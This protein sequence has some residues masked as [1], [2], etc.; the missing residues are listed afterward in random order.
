MTPEQMDMLVAAHL[1]AENTGDVAA[2]VAVYT[3]DV[4]HDVVGAPAGP[5]RGPEAARHRYEQLLKEVR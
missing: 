4:E 3:E 5:L 1:D 2:A